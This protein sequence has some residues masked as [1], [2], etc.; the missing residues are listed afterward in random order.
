MRCGDPMVA[1]AV[2]GELTAL[3]DCFSALLFRACTLASTLFCSLA[4]VFA[5]EYHRKFLSHSVRP[6]GRSLPSSRPVVIA[7]D[8]IT[9]SPGSSLVKVSHM[10]IRTPLPVFS[11]PAGRVWTLDADWFA[12][13]CCVVWPIV[14]VLWE[15]WSNLRRVR[16]EARSW[17]TIR[18][19]A[20]GWT[21]GCRSAFGT[22][23]LAEI[24]ERAG[25]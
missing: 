7:P 4:C 25:D 13:C 15:G 8:S 14:R 21:T 19:E 17:S 12:V 5:Q 1:G 6:D 24:Q 22:A 11:S 9:S 3:C 16:S 10:R 23:V 2:R 20:T 18:H